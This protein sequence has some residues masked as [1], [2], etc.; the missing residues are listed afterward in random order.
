M[1]D[2]DED[3]LT[4]SAVIVAVIAIKRRNRRQQ[5]RSWWVRNWISCTAQLGCHEAVLA[6]GRPIFVQKAYQNFCRISPVDYPELLAPVYRPACI[7]GHS[8]W[9][10]SCCDIGLRFLATSK[11]VSS[12]HYP[13][14]HL[15]IRPLCTFSAN[16]RHYISDLSVA[17][18]ILLSTTCRNKQLA[19]LSQKACNLLTLTM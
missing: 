18:S 15:C 12:D 11:Q 8:N 13:Q 1:D 10:T 16:V 6:G 5:R 19:Y 4:L 7:A 14:F 17:W 2:D 9:R 3:V